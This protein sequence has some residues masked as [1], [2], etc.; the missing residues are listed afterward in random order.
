MSD[1]D[2][3]ETAALARRVGGELEGDGARRIRGLASPARESASPSGNASARTTNA[4]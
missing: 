4:S 2:G 1:P 3:I